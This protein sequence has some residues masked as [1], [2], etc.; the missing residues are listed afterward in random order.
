MYYLYETST[1]IGLFKQEGNTPASLVNFHPFENIDQAFEVQKSMIGGE[2]TKV[3]QEFVRANFIKQFKGETIGI[4]DARLAQ[5]LKDK[6]DIKAVC[7]DLALRIHRDIQ[8]NLYK[9]VPKLNKDLERQYSAS[10]AHNCSRYQVQFNSES[11]DS[12][13]LQ[14]INLLDE[15]EKEINNYVMRLMEWAIWSFPEC[16]KIVTDHKQYCRVMGVIGGDKKQLMNP[17]V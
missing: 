2:L 15:S 17:E 9:L 12:M 7:N 3:V 16:S 14:S 4:A 10:L 1:G 5:A 11:V 13:I 6:F 8:H